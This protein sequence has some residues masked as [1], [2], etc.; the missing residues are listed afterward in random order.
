MPCLNS[1]AKQLFIIIWLVMIANWDKSKMLK[2]YL[3]KVFEIDSSWRMEALEDEDLRPLWDS[4]QV[5]T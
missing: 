3:K 5:N 4:L 1:P 2:K